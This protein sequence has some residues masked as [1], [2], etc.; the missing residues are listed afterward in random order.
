MNRKNSA[1]ALRGSAC[2]EKAHALRLVLRST[3]ANLVLMIALEVLLW[4]A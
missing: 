3:V 2:P 4:M 1:S